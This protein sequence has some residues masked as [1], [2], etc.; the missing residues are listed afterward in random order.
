MNTKLTQL[1]EEATYA[2]DYPEDQEF[3][4]IP[5][6]AFCK[7]FAELIIKECANIVRDCNDRRIPLSMVANYVEQFKR[8]ENE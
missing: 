7:K 6:P 5:N 4:M 3:I 1:S 2:A 8:L